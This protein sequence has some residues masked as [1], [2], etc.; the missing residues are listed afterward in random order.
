MNSLLA[1]FQSRIDSS[2]PKLS[3]QSQGKKL[4]NCQQYFPSRKT[5]LHLKV[6]HLSLPWCWKGQQS[7]VRMH[8]N[9]CN[10]QVCSL[11]M[12]WQTKK[13]WNQKQ[14]FLCT[15]KTLQFHVF[16]LF[17][18]FFSS[19]KSVF[20]LWNRTICVCSCGIIRFVSA[21]QL[22]DCCSCGFLV[23]MQTDHGQEREITS[24][25][26]IPVE[27]FKKANNHVRWD[28]ERIAMGLKGSVSCHKD[29]TMMNWL[30]N[31]RK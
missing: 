16:A 23:I 21:S 9:W 6:F 19:Y 5:N 26:G 25:S 27:E 30:G 1:L 29:C 18:S 2:F 22:S 3:R 8:V 20:P 17:V 28:G 10:H 7:K 31:E 14:S 4:I 24:S 13:I 11:R 15:D 12:P